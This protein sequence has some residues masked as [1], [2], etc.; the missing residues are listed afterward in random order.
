MALAWVLGQRGVG[1]SGQRGVCPEVPEGAWA[2]PWK[3]VC[4][5]EGVWGR[6]GPGL[7]CWG[8]MCSPPPLLV[9]SDPS[10]LPWQLHS[11][12]SLVLPL[13]G[14]QYGVSKALLHLL[15]SFWNFP[16]AVSSIRSVLPLPV[17]RAGSFSLLILPGVSPTSTPC[18]FLQP[19]IGFLQCSLQ[20]W[21]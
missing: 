20:C 8:H 3:L 1:G 4:G 5:R 18:A 19:S 11:S 14:P 21:K 13:P 12:S 17:S 2:E 10:F 15:P 9:P 7:G 6:G 16:C